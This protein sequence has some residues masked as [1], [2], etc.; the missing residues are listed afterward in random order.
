[1]TRWTL[2]L[3]TLSGCG[4][5]LD[6]SA[7]DSG[8]DDRVGGAASGNSENPGSGGPVVDQD[9]D[10][11]AAGDADCDDNDPDVYVGH[12]EVCDGKDNDCNGVVD[13]LD[14]LLRSGPCDATDE[15]GDGRT[16]EVDCDDN[17]PN[18]WPGNS[19]TCDDGQDNNCDDLVDGDDPECGALVDTADPGTDTS[20]TADPGPQDCDEDGRTSD[21]DCDD[22]DDEVHPDHVEVC[23]DEKDNDCDGLAD[24]DDPDCDA[25]DTDT[26]VVALESGEARITVL[27]FVAATPAREPVHLKLWSCDQTTWVGCTGYMSSDDP[28]IDAAA[29]P[30]LEAIIAVNSNADEVKIGGRTYFDESDISESGPACNG[31]NDELYDCTWDYAVTSVHAYITAQI[32]FWDGTVNVCTSDG[33]DLLCY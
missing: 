25:M 18:N 13:D 26:G 19:E 33:S 23:G 8:D 15:D 32:E 14:P 27:S 16:A 31:S 17:D 30:G 20:D 10:G 29:T 4:L 22:Y 6:W 7:L 2:V 3:L 5:G 9:R 24:G 11:R 1:M 12:P 28:I 21:V